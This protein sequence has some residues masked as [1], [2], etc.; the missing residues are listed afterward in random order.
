MTIRLPDGAQLYIDG[1]MPVVAA[2]LYL[3]TRGIR[4]TG[5]VVNGI[6]LA[7]RTQ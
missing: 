4:L 7:E 1:N 6:F 3:K 2:V 5:R